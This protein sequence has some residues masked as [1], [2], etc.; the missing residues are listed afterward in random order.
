[1]T[2]ASSAR[3]WSAYQLAVFAD[4]ASGKGHT[5]V[6]AVAGSGKTSTILEGF[7]HVPQGLKGLMCAFNKE[8]AKELASRA[9]ASVKTWCD[10]S[11][12]HSYGLKQITRAYG[13]LKVDNFKTYTIL[14]E[15]LKDKI[16]FR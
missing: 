6:Q 8:I 4:I 11:T 16:S 3:I 1:M 12:L 7:N 9:D 15:N 10:I 5:F 14:S 2:T 13:Q